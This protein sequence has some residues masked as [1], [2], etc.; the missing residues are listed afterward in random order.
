MNIITETRDYDRK[1]IFRMSH[2]SDALKDV[3]EGEVLSVAGYCYAENE[4]R[5][6]ELQRLLYMETVDIGNNVRWVATT[7]ETVYREMMEIWDAFY[8]GSTPVEVQHV[9]GISKSGRTYH[10]VKVI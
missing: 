7:S 1:D 3:G 5:G 10:T 2:N 6:G 4:N 9:T 8:D